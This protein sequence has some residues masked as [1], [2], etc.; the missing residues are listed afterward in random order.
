MV[1]KALRTKPVYKF[2]FYYKNY[3][4]RNFKINLT[5][6]N[7]KWSNLKLLTQ[8]QPIYLCHFRKLNIKRFYYYKFNNKQFLKKYLVNYKE[9]N[10][11]THI[12]SLN[13]K[14]IERRLDYN[15]YKAKF[16]P[17]LFAAHFYITNGYI[18][19]NQKCIKNCNFILQTNDRVT[20]QSKIY[21]ICKQ[22]LINT[23]LTKNETLN[24]I[25]NLEIDFTTCSFIFLNNKNYNLLT[26]NNQLK[27]V[28]FLIKKNST[29]QQNNYFKFFD[30]IFIHNNY[31]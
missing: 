1:T 29:L 22:T 13:F 7:K 8:Q 14:T 28:D 5:F 25:K 9:Y 15:L 26:L 16:V 17:S 23:F 18:F 20:I 31:H 30:H 10:F 12:I 4:F 2:Y 6:K 19:V 21:N 24:Y 11:K 27:K 3:N